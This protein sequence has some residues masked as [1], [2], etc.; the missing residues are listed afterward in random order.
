MPVQLQKM[1]AIKSARKKLTKVTTEERIKTAL[2]RNVPSTADAGIETGNEWPMYSEKPSGKRT[3]LYLV[4]HLDA[5]IL[6]LD[7]CKRTIDAPVNNVKKQMTR[8]A[9][10]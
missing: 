8:F 7:I 10:P 5:K 6:R 1:T 9:E 3:E 4:N 2:S